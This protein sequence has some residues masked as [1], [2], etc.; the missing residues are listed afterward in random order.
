MSQKNH[1]V[2][3]Y[4]LAYVLWIVSTGLGVYVLVKGRDT[5]LLAMVVNSSLGEPTKSEQFYASLRTAAASSWT[6]MIVGLL[7]LILLVGIENFYRMSVPSG[8]LLR[9]F[10][11]VS[12]IECAVLFITHSIYFALLQTFRPVG[13]VTIL[14]L[15]GELIL[16]ALIF[17][18]YSV[19]RKK[20]LVAL[21]P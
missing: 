18:I 1:P 16:A 11:L 13:W 7:I 9:R 6:I 17:W 21:T 8:K 10:F 2:I 14:I 20:P 19:L 4:I 3:R 5:V 15:A 12:G